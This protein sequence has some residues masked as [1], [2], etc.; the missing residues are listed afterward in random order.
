[1][2]NIDLRPLPS[3]LTLALLAAL[4]VPTAQAASLTVDPSA[5]D[6]A[7]AGDGKCSLREAVLSVNAGANVGDCVAT[8]LE[9]YGSN[10]T[11]NLPAGVYTLTRMGLDETYV[12]TAPGNPNS[13]P[14][15][16]NVGDA[17]MGD[18]DLSK[19]VKIIGA[20]AGSTT[21]AW[22]SDAAV[23]RDRIFHI[24]AATG[25]VAV[26]LQGLTLNNGQTQESIIKIGPTSTYGL[27]PTLYYL[28]RAGGAV[29]VGPAA[30]VVLSDPNKTGQASSEGRGGSKKP[31][32]TG[33][34]GGATLTLEMK[35][36]TVSGNSAQG[37][38]GGIYTAAALTAS[39][40]L[41]ADN[42][43]STNGGGIYNEGNTAISGSTIRD[44]TAEGGGGFFGTGSNVVNFSAVTI[45]GNKAVGGGGI[46]GRSGVTL[47]LVNSTISANIGSDTGGGVYTNGAAELRFVTIARN[48]AG[49]DA[50]TAG[51]GINTFPSSSKLVTMK[52]VLLADNRKGYTDG[53]TAAE[54][55][56]LVS[57]NCGSTGT[58]LNVASRGYNLSSDSSCQ[59]VL[60]L[61]GDQNG[62]DA[63]IG[64]LADNGG[65]S[66]TH[67][68]LPNSPALGAGQA[69]ADIQSDQRGETRDATPDIG[70]FEVPTAVVTS[71]DTTA[72]GSSSGGGCTVNPDAG[73]DPGLPALVLAALGGLWL[74]RRRQGGGGST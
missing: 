40:L 28:R 47:R 19:S 52:N 7:T 55:A 41:V 11:I 16:S 59:S 6:A 71:T 2:T 10:D 15:V 12:D 64:D 36:V 65:G 44:N 57:A 72:S 46:S 29:A 42:S 45:S 35:Q 3:L 60:S 24:N 8:V 63:K 32:T 21:I 67:A 48:L 30:A 23:V 13:L 17:T 51:S 27:L 70:A 74:R 33:E 4:A 66:L 58:S 14:T 9:A 38:G 73:F 68:L 20:G 25:T 49:A 22:S 69:E 61:A 62:K 54:I 34:E 37:D 31:G 43:A 39:G 5:A 53:M 18:L 56:A 50:S 1:M 26:S